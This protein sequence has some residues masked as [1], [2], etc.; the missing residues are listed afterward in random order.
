MPLTQLPQSEPVEVKVPVVFTAL[1][2]NNKGRWPLHL[3]FEEASVFFILFLKVSALVSDQSRAG[4]SAV[5]PLWSCAAPQT[6][7]KPRIGSALPSTVS[8]C[9]N[10]IPAQGGGLGR[11]GDEQI[12]K[13]MWPHRSSA[14]SFDLLLIK[15]PRCYGASPT[16][17]LPT[18]SPNPSA[19]RLRADYH[20]CK[21]SCKPRSVLIFYYYSPTIA[22]E[23]VHL[24]PLNFRLCQVVPTAEE[25]HIIQS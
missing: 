7:P 23:S 22:F 5:R 24:L 20:Q 9:A 14:H 3:A 8:M 19:I 6:K 12:L 18:I 1:V 15:E 25:G 16:S 13:S 4:F 11:G 2:E 10:N 17:G 21:C